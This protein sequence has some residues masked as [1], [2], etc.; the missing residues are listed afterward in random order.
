MEKHV[1]NTVTTETL[2][3]QPAFSLL[4]S[5]AIE[6]ILQSG[7]ILEL[8]ARQRL[9]ELVCNSPNADEHYCFVLDGEVAI[10]IDDAGNEND[11]SVGARKTRGEYVGWF[12]NGDFF[13]D[14]Y[15]ELG[16]KQKGCV[17][18]CVATT[19]AALLATDTA[20]LTGIMQQHPAWAAQ[21]A[22]NMAASRQRFLSHQEPTRRLVQDF[23]LGQG[24]GNSRRVR[25]SETT[26]CFDCDKCEAACAKRHGH[27]RMARV[28]ARLGRL[29]FQ[30][31]CL[32][33]SSQP[34]LKSCPSDAIHTNA[35]GELQITDNCTGCGACARKCPYGAIRIIDVPYTSADFS[36]AVPG[37]NDNGSTAIPGLFVAG[38]VSGPRPTKVA[39]QEAKR[40]V[41]AM[42]LGQADQLSRDGQVLDAIIVGGGMA[43][44]AAAERCNERR[45]RFMVIE[46]KSPLSGKA[47]RLA[48]TMPIQAGMAVLGVTSGGE[49]LLRVEV[50]G[51]VYVA[52]NVLV[53]TG[54]PAP[55]DRSLLRQA[56]VPM[57]E[58]STKEMAAYASARGTHAVGI[59]CDNCA[60]YSDRACLRACPTG[61]LIELRPQELFFEPRGDQGGQ[62]FSGVAFVEG[63]AEHRARRKTHRA[64]AAVLSVALVLA[65]VVVGLECFLRRALPEQSAV[66]MI[67]AWLGNLDPVWYSSGKGYGHWLGYVGTAF[68]LM[69]LLYPLRTR[70]GVL[71]S[72]GAQSWWLTIHLWVGFI[73]ATLVT[74][75]A[76]FK[77]DRWVALACYAMWTV[78]LSGAIGR[79]LYG[80][81]HSGIGLIELEREALSRSAF[82]QAAFERL[83]RN[84][85]KLLA[86]E[87]Q[88]PGRIYTEV[89]VMLWHELRDFAILLWLRFAGLSQIP[90]RRQRRQ[91]LRYLA[92]MASH[93]RACRYLESA[94]RLLRYWNWVHIVLTIAMFVLSG[95]HITYGFMY[96]AV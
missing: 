91:T 90:D 8:K 65:L 22:R 33:C 17:L 40:A 49:R 80:M 60:G 18:D 6:R 7:R 45:L 51:G 34:C 1:A 2:R 70:C 28:H 69:T 30:Q 42:Q 5:P 29:A 87:T 89:F 94:R 52:R 24:Y 21:L 13:S 11:N 84:V 72:W 23:Y 19:P 43:G 35:V 44:M 78:V 55:G 27:A 81:I 54:R 71:K 85:L 83:N 58:P 96:K 25:V 16:E 61:S 62:L 20:T 10:V 75:H 39:I 79:Y 67:R 68:M 92:D 64:L 95:F 36:N 3:A 88:K 48:A 66:G 9:S 93:R 38:D 57:I 53:C 47:A 63:V 4:S 82:R 37:S 50:A 56:G 86:A 46:K 14:G 77:L 26:R 73:G 31:F 32:G 15:L 12:G 74:Y 76:A 41:D 59:K